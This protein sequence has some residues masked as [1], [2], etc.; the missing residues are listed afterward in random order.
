M[1]RNDIPP[2]R[3]GVTHD[4]DAKAQGAEDP[5]RRRV[6]RGALAV[7]CTLL[8]PVTLVGCDP[9][10]KVLSGDDSPATPQ[11]TKV[12]QASVQYQTNPNGGEQC[13]QCQHFIAESNNCQMVAG[14]I[15]NT[16]WCSLWAAA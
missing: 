2:H 3:T 6:L 16:G 7:G 13:G 10:M 5:G 1:N 4:A 8:I 9:K 14:N 11:A 12:S 15:S